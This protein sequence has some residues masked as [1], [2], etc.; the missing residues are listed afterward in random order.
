MTNRLTA[1]FVAHLARNFGSEQNTNS[2]GEGWPDSIFHAAFR[3]H[4]NV[5]ICFFFLEK[6]TTKMA[7]KHVCLDNTSKFFPSKF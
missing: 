5:V 6:T 3:H 1:R 4:S 7:S 2:M